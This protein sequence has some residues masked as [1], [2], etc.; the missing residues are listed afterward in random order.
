MLLRV[1][2]KNCFQNAIYPFLKIFT[3]EVFLLCFSVKITVSKIT[4]LLFEMAKDK[5]DI[6]NPFS[7]VLMLPRNVI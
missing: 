5:S 2:M 1:D 7:T 4:V 6:I 3:N